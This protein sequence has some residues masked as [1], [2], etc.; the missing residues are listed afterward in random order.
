MC[1]KKLQFGLYNLGILRAFSGDQ[2][3]HCLQ[4]LWES[5]IWD[6][7]FCKECIQNAFSL[8]SKGVGFKIQDSKIGLG[9]VAYIYIYIYTYIP[10]HP[11]TTKTMRRTLHLQPTCGLDRVHIS[12]FAFAWPSCSFLMGKTWKYHEI[13]TCPM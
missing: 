9:G 7:G 13:R 5:W 3:L 8:N 11:S 1:K 4:N 10:L 6:L 12:C 2:K